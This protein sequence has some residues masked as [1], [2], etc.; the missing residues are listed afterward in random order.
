M[1]VPD[2]YKDILKVLIEKTDQGILTWT[3]DGLHVSS[4]VDMAKFSLWAGVDERTNESFVALGLYTDT[5]KMVD[6]WYLD[7]SETEYLEVFRLYTAAKRHA[8]GVPSLLKNL[9]Q[10]ISEMKKIDL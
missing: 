2:D 7:E 1:P 4:D 3:D 10:R 8:N 6:S 9:T 5:G